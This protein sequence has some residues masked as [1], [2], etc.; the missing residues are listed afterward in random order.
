MVEGAQLRASKQQHQELNKQ[1]W[2]AL[3]KRCFFF[4]LK[5]QKDLGIPESYLSPEMMVQTA[6]EKTYAG[7]RPWDGNVPI[8]AHLAGVVKSLYSNESRKLR[9]HQAW[10]NDEKGKD[11]QMLQKLDDFIHLKQLV[12]KLRDEDPGL[13]KFFMQATY[14]LIIGKCS[15]DAE[16][17]KEIGISASTYHDNRK[18]VEEVINRG[19]RAEIGR[20]EGVRECSHEKDR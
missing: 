15:T 17:A 8:Y 19:Q 12:K 9:N 3:G 7:E 16:V 1:N 20:H 13:A 6:I 11:S 4:A 10:E 14:H 5:C 18:K 2:R